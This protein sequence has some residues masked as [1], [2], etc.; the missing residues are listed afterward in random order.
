MTGILNSF[1]FIVGIIVLT[2][3][4]NEKKLHIPQDIA[5][6][7]VSFLFSFVIVVLEKIGIVNFNDTIVSSLKSNSLDNFLLECTLCFMLFAGASK[8]HLNKF[9]KNI[10]PIA[11]LS[12]ITTVVSTI[13]Y[14]GF[15]FLIARLLGI[16]L[17]IWVSMMLGAIIS[18]TDPIAAT[19]ILNK[20]GLSK[21]FSSVIEGE[22]LFNDGFAVALFI[23]FKN[24]IISGSFENIFLLVVKEMFG[25]IAVGLILSM[26]LHKVLKLTNDPIIHILIS[27][28]DVSL[29]Y[30]L[31]EHFGFSGVIASVVCGMY[32]S[33]Q[34]KK[35]VRWK[36][37]VDPKGLYN[38]FWN[39]IDSLLNSALFV[40]VGL[41]VLSIDI[42]N[43]ILILIPIAILLNLV[44]RYAGVF[45]SASLIGKKKIPSKYDT[46]EFTTLL[47]W[48]GLKGGLSLALALTLKGVLNSSEYLIVVNMVL[49]TILFTTIVQGLTIGKVYK[50]I[51]RKREEKVIL[52]SLTVI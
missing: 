27:L 30:I 24:I 3:V 18:P 20:L 19:G 11:S 25:A 46:K 14:G 1:V 51:E 6:L 15:F 8:V 43:L 26:L 44:C 48:S 40:L 39:I 33:Y 10:L 34:D 47:T 23:F 13:L 37:V 31:C 35:I 29:S 5:V 38:D 32:F 36:E 2:S 9:V 41:S 52:K 16:N 49:V 45:V 4:I 21:S 28:L 22:A 42:S 50:E 17:N 7:M 12:I